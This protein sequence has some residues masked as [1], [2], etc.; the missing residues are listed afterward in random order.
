ME[1]QQ[2][3]I[4]GRRKAKP[5]DRRWGRTKNGNEQICC[6]FAITEEGPHKS[7]R[8]FWYGYFTEKSIDRTLESLEHCG[9]DGASLK[10]L[11]GF[12][13]KEVELDIGIEKGSDGNEYVVVRW[14]NALGDGSGRKM[15]ELDA[16]GLDALEARAKGAMLAR[17]ESRSAEGDASFPHGANAPAGGD[18]PPV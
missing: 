5:I 15:L 16:N 7:K 17:K 18:G 4:V 14:V 2:E 1:Q 6:T 3:S 8:L 13:S 12:G 11:K 10:E 9:W